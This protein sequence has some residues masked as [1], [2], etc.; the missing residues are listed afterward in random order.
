MGLTVLQ[1]KIFICESLPIVNRRTTCAIEFGEIATLSHEICDYSMEFTALV[2]ELITI[3]ARA[4]FREIP[5]G[6]GDCVAEKAYDYSS[7]LVI[8]D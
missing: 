1:F 5:D 6:D 2:G 8:V 7:N 3:F 4:K